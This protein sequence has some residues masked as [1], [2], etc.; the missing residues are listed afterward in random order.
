MATDNIGEGANVNP[1]LII[2]MKRYIKSIYKAF[3]ELT[4]GY[5]IGFVCRTQ[6]I[7]CESGLIAD[8]ILAVQS[9]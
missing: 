7:L 6:V 1:N 3:T 8:R 9:S 4:P 5:G 2:D